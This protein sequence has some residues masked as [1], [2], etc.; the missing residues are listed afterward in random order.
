[1]TCLACDNAI[2]I[3]QGYQL[4]QYIPNCRGLH[5]ARVDRFFGFVCYELIQVFILEAAAGLKNLS[6]RKAAKSVTKNYEKKV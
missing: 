1:M 2:Q 6:A 4:R 5:W 3:F